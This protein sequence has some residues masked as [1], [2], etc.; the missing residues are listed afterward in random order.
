MTMRERFWVAGADVGLD[1]VLGEPTV[2]DCD[3]EGEARANL[4]APPPLLD[5]P[6]PPCDAVGKAAAEEA[7]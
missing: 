2:L 6:P 4:V 7:S 3:S 5:A 1:V